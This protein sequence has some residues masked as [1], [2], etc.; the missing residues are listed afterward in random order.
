[1]VTLS[2]RL[3]DIKQGKEFDVSE[4]LTPEQEAKDFCTDHRGIPPNE[5]IEAL[6]V[7]VFKLRK[8]LADLYRLCIK[9]AQKSD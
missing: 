8:Q 1:M 4:E 6:A 9:M 3:T 7:K 2:T 5:V